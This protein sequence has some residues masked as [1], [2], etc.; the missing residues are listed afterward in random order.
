MNI[1]VQKRKMRAI[2]RF[3][4]S[5]DRVHSFYTKSN[6]VSRGSEKKR[7]LI[8]YQER[9]SRRPTEDSKIVKTTLADDVVNET[10]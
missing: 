10:G 2:L 6:R 4:P 3:V 9:R 7:E 1:G 5:P 8:F